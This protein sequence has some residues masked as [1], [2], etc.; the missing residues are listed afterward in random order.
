[1]RTKLLLPILLVALVVLVVVIDA[2]RRTAEDQLAQLSLRLEQLQGNTQQNQEKAREI[3]VRV[4]KHIDL[5]MDTEPTVAMIVDVTKLRERNP[6]YNKAENGDYLIVTPSRA[7]LFD[8]E[9]DVIIDV[10]PVQIEQPAPEGTTAATSQA[11][12]QAASQAQ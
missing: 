7:V 6:F 1:M 3:L 11:A 12:S 10:V 5:P 2:R 9:M 4:R 8:P